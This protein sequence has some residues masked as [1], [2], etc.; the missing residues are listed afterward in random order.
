MNHPRKG[1]T[2]R[3]REK[4]DLQREAE[5][6]TAQNTV[7]QGIP[8]STPGKAGQK[9]VQRRAGVESDANARS[10]GKEHGIEGNAVHRF[11]HHI[12][13]AVPEADMTVGHL[14]HLFLCPPHC[15]RGKKR[16]GG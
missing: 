7:G 2:E 5:G 14:H 9:P 4:S 13:L 16:I 8:E 3:R 6:L 11:L 1:G 10:K 12:G 15:G